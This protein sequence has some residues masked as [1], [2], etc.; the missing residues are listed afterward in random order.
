MPLSVKT[1]RT[2]RIRIAVTLLSGL[3][4]VLLGFAILYLQAERT[5]QQNT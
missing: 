1:S 5:L 3:L 2:R 4:P